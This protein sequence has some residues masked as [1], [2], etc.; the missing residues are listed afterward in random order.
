MF[1]GIVATTAP[2]TKITDLP[3]LR[4][5]TLR[6]PWRQRFM[7]RRGASVALD[8]VCMTVTKKSGRN[9]T[10]D[11]M[12]ETL[13]KTTIGTVKEKDEMN[14]ER[15]FRANTEVGGHIL[16]GHVTGKAKIVRIDKPQNNRVLEFQIPKRYM[17]YIFEKGF[18]ALNGC[19]LTIVDVDQDAGTFTVHLIPETLSITTFDQKRVGD[20]INF[21]VDSKTQTLVDTA[22]RLQKLESSD[23]HKQY[24]N[25]Q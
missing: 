19:S 22:E 6:F 5:M 24:M 2:I 20:E 15:S 23:L 12:E 4:T 10:F 11:A 18:V 21:E 17:K 8:G 25:N 3:G 16:S 13:E 9:V 7:L 14:I 1:T